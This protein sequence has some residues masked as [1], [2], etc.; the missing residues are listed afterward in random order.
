MYDHLGSSK[1]YDGV[2]TEVIGNCGIGVAPVS[3]DKKEQ[4]ITYLNTRLIGFPPGQAGAPLE[5]HGRISDGAP[6]VQSRNQCGA[7]GLPR[8]HPDQ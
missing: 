6:G 3:D 1:I 5:Y 8:R 4:L 7:S 2:T